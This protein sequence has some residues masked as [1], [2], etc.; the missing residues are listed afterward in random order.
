MHLAHAKVK[1]EESKFREREFPGAADTPK[2]RSNANSKVRFEKWEVTVKRPLRV[3]VLV[4][5]SNHPLLKCR[6]L[7]VSTGQSMT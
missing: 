5:K 2:G 3:G 6:V 7:V 1:W 4:A